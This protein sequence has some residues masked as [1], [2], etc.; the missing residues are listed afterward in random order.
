MSKVKCEQSELSCIGCGHN[1]EH[2]KYIV[3]EGEKCSIDGDLFA[4]ENKNCLECVY[5]E[6][7]LQWMSRKNSKHNIPP[8]DL[9]VKPDE[10][11]EYRKRTKYVKCVK[12]L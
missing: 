12:C 1:G 7:C 10:C 9:F 2:K 3:C 8:I 5:S 6:N 11:G 4:K